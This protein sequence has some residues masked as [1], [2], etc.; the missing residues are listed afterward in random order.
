MSTNPARTVIQKKKG[1]DF[2]DRDEWARDEILGSMWCDNCNEGN[3]G[4]EN[5]Q[6]YEVKGVVYLE[7]ICVQCGEPVVITIADE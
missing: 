6:E 2:R 3:L 5:P 7:G 1:R 4:V